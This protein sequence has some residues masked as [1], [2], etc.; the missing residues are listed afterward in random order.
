MIKK[1]PVK[2]FRAFRN[3]FRSF[4]IITPVCK[5]PS[6]P[7]GRIPEA[8]VGVSGMLFGYRKGCVSHSIQEN[9]GTL[10]TLVIDLAIQTNMLQKEMSLGMVRITLECEKRPDNINNKEKMKLLDESCWTMFVNGKKVVIVQR[11]MP[12]KKIFILWRYLR[13]CRWGQASCPQSATWKD[14]WTMKWHI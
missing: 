10:P 13:R 6:L 11:E 3:V 9:S 4:P 1:H 5:L 8:K 14:T 12:R 2:I 7:D